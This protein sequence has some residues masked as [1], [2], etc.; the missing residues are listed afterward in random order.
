MVV[1]KMRCVSIGME[2][3]GRIEERRRHYKAVI[4]RQAQDD[5]NLYEVES[6]LN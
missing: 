2:H 4:L 3:L 5:C 6:S 1:K